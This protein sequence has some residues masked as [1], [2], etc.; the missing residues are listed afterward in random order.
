MR[1]A[2]DTDAVEDRATKIN[3]LLGRGYV[4]VLDADGEPTDAVDEFTEG[5]GGRFRTW[6]VEGVTL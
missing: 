5:D 6:R 3:D 4:T 2:D 1:D